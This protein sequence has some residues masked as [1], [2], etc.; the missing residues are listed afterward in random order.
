MRLTSCRWRFGERLGLPTSDRET[1]RRL[2]EEALRGA[3]ASSS[4]FVPFVR[5][6][7]FVS[8]QVHEEHEGEGAAGL[9]YV[10]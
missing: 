7:S 1:L 8:H 9:T 10:L 5:T 4:C 3:D 2:A 6:P